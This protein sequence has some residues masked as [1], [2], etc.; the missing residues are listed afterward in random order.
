MDNLA[1]MQTFTYLLV[2]LLIHSFFN[3]NSH[4]LQ[5]R[6][7][8]LHNNDN[9]DDVSNYSCKFWVKQIIKRFKLQNEQQK[10]L[11]LKC[12]DF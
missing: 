4:Y 9:N 11:I 5:H 3:C 6:Y 2:H 7:G 1:R 8:Y 12:N 10:M